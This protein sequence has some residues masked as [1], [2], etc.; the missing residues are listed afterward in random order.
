MAISTQLCGTIRRRIV[1]VFLL[2]LAVVL[3][4]GRWWAS[5]RGSMMRDRLI[6]DR[7]GTLGRGHVSLLGAICTLL[8][9]WIVLGRLAVW[10][11]NR[12]R[13]RRRVRLGLGNELW[14]GVCV[15]CNAGRGLR[16]IEAHGRTALLGSNGLVLFAAETEEDASADDREKGEDTDDYASNPGFGFGFLGP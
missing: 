5:R 4:L 10:L 6:V 11:G 3:L 12:R 8:G 9:I 16:G 2:R 14:F 15:A 13:G 1:S 7:D